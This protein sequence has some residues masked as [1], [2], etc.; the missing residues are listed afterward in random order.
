MTEKQWKKG[1]YGFDFFFISYIWRRKRFIAKK[2]FHLE[3]YP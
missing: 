2:K 1:I 3:E